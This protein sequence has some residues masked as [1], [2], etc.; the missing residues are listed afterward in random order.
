MGLEMTDLKM[1]VIKFNKID[2]LGKFSI[3]ILEKAESHESV[4]F[5]EEEDLELIYNY[6]RIALK[7]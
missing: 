5:L 4:V 3:R 2:W 7:K 1:D 6:L